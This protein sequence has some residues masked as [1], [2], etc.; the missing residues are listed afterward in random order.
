MTRPPDD[1][2]VLRHARREALIIL[3]VWAACTIYCCAYAYLFG[4]DRP[5]RPLGAAE[6][7]PVLGVP[8]WIAW[9]VFLPWGLCFAFTA[10]F[11]GWMM[12]D[13]DLGSDH[14]ADLGDEIREGA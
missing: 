3:G 2:P 8:S 9:G 10:W 5:G 11:A 7:R 1:D 6:V 12:V 14:A 4:Y 13:D